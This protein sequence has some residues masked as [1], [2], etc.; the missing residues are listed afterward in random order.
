MSGKAKQGISPKDGLCSSDGRI[1][2]TAGQVICASVQGASH[3]FNNTECQ[4]AYKVMMFGDIVIL[5]VADGHGSDSCPHSKTGANIAV[6][7]F[8]R[9]MRKFCGVYVSEAGVLED[10]LSREGSA[11]ARGIDAA[12]KRA[13]ETHSSD[14]S[15][16][17]PTIWK[18]HGTTLIGAVITPTFCFALQ[19]GDGDILRV[20][21]QRVR[22]V[23][24]CEKILGVQTHSLCHDGAWRNAVTV[25]EPCR[26]HT[27]LMMSTDG[28]A[29]S[30]PDETAFHGACREYYTAITQHGAELVQENLSGWLDE[31]SENGSGD[32]ITVLIAM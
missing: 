26:A 23:I 20:D 31:T 3:K 19:I 28:F 2:T 7:V 15:L 9:I 5:A 8:C 4:D 11:V 6:D 16:N 18:Q 14:N 21:S 17:S 24:A 25:V 32:D 22:A 29:N 1:L 27:A 10:Y 13:V 30:Y 12:W